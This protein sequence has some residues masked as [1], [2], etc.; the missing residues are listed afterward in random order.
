LNYL[1]TVSGRSDFSHLAQF[2][3]VYH[4]QEVSEAM[5]SDAARRVTGQE[6]DTTYGVTISWKHRYILC[7]R[8][9]ARRWGSQRSGTTFFRISGEEERNFCSMDTKNE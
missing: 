4:G 1:M 7:C 5:F 8:A 3:E 9:A 2:P 6:R